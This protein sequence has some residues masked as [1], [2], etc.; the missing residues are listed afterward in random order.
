MSDDLNVKH[1]ILSYD[2]QFDGGQ[3]GQ[4]SVTKMRIYLLN[5]G[6]KFHNFGESRHPLIVK[7]TASLIFRQIHPWGTRDDEY[8]INSEVAWG[9]INAWIE[10]GCSSRRSP[11]GGAESSIV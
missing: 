8:N 6:E 1:L 7:K 5:P 11:S 10:D 3:E 2:L 9:A 4:V